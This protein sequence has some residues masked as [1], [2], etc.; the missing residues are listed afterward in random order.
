MTS[1][2]EGQD[3][4][5]FLK[6]FWTSRFGIVPKANLFP[7][8][9]STYIESTGTEQLSF[10]LADAAEKLEQIDDPNHPAW[11][12]I[13]GVAADYLRQI[14]T[15]GSKQVRPVILSALSRFEKGELESFLYILTVTLV[16]YQL[17]GRQRTGVLEKSLGTLSERIWESSITTTD[18]AW[19]HLAPII[20]SD[21]DFIEDF[22]THLERK[23]YRLGYLLAAIEASSKTNDLD[24]ER[25]AKDISSLLDT[26]QVDWIA[27]PSITSQGEESDNIDKLIG[28]VVL[29]ERSLVDQAK[30][31]APAE[32]MMKVY[33]QSSLT[34]TRSASN[35]FFWSRTFV[36]ERTRSLA[37]AAPSAWPLWK[38][39]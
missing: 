11:S 37:S 29:L 16:R 2:I 1:R 3:A 26:C 22:S 13:P 21:E 20:P 12:D 7:R 19:R 23:T 18:E 25:R 31:E 33:P 17:I 14:S 8:I 27:K 4:D 32:K 28:N 34:T 36:V 6:V 5:D 35:H 9:R 10:E 24:L 38:N 39:L 15:I 30:I